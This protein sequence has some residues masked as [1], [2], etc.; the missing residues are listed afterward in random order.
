MSDLAAG[1]IATLSN[2]RD[3][4]RG[5]LGS[6]CAHLQGHIFRGALPT[7]YCHHP[8]YGLVQ[9]QRAASPS[10]KQVELQNCAGSLQQVASAME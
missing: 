9:F 2:Y 7:R 10:K 8:S 3:G 4:D 1:K 5:D 6:I